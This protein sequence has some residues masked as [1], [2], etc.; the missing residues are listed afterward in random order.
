MNEEFRLKLSQ[1]EKGCYD[2]V[3]DKVENTID[4]TY[5]EISQDRIDE[6]NNFM[7]SW[8][9]MVYKEFEITERIG[10]ILTE[11]DSF[12][13]VLNYFQENNPD[14]IDTLEFDKRISELDK[15]I[16]NLEKQKLALRNDIKQSSEVNNVDLEFE[17]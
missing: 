4:L 17:D 7:S 11:K 6:L 1:V 16:G 3:E 5:K 2:I 14:A 13:M 9:D 12:I 8:N 10:V 15:K